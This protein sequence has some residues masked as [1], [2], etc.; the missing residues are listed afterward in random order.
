M[1]GG[2]HSYLFFNF[3]WYNHVTYTVQITRFWFSP[4][5][6]F[7]NFSNLIVILILN[8]YIENIYS[9]I[10]SI[11][12]LDVNSSMAHLEDNIKVW[13]KSVSKK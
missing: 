8:L 4:K 11:R 10:Y 7:F 5:I 3:L 2:N 6:F 12:V 9:K 1:I 13:I